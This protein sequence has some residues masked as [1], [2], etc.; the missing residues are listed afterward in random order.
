[1]YLNRY[2]ARQNENLNLFFFQKEKR[3]KHIQEQEL[4]VQCQ[5]SNERINLWELEGHIKKVSYRKM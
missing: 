1:M 4:E 3:L 2:K 5:L